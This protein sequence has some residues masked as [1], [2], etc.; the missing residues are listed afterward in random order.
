MTEAEA[1]QLEQLEKQF[2]SGVPSDDLLTRCGEQISQLTELQ[3]SRKASELSSV[4]T[5]RLETLET[6]FIKGVPSEEDVLRHE[7]LLNQADS[8]R[9]EKLRLTAAI[10]TESPAAP[11]SQKKFHSL[12]FPA[13]IFGLLAAAAGIFLLA[14][15]VFESHM[16]VGGICAA[17]GVVALVAA[18]IMQN[19]HNLMAKMQAQASTGGMTAAQRSLIQENEQAASTMESV[20]SAFLAD[21]PAD[22]NGS[23]RRR[24]AELSTNRS[25]YLPLL[26]R[27]RKLAQQAAEQD[28]RMAELTE[29]LHE[30]L[31]PYFHTILDF[32]TA[33]QTLELR[34][35]QFQ[36][37]SH[38]Q[39]EIAGRNAVLTD[40]IAKLEAT[41]ST[42][43]LPYCGEVSH[44]TFRSALDT[45]RRDADSYTTA[46]AHLTQ[47]A[48]A[49]ADRDAQCAALLS[50]QNEFCTAYGLT[51][52]IHDRQALKAAERDA[53]A[54]ARLT[55]EAAL[56]DKA[57]QC[58]IEEHGHKPASELNASDYDLDGLKSAEQQLITK[59]NELHGDILR[60]EQR[61]RQLR[62]DIDRIPDLT[63]E[64]TR[65]TEQKAADTESRRLLDSTVEYL[66]KARES[67][68][69][70]Y[71]GGVQGHFARYLNRLTGEETAHIAVNTDLEVQLE[72]AGSARALPHFSAGQADAVHL[73][74]RLALSDALFEEGTAF[75]ILDDPFVN[76]DDHH[77]AQAL[78]LL[79]EL[80][81]DRQIVY[82]V[83]NS[84][85]SL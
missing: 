57:M 25:L 72:R 67:L 42:F 17:L 83:C 61:R 1:R 28:K 40:E 51:I 41:F 27:S 21:Y 49:L 2:A 31:S 79:R 52:A 3:H 10:P 23:L 54:I 15:P 63:D 85:R 50:Q 29:A 45:L 32:H 64:L 80:A 5:A 36:Q 81:H 73:C 43:L 77:T 7:H 12:F 37:I 14:S 76:L 70:S 6:F 44:N 39:Q 16:V 13:L 74:M 71:L 68:S 65:L 53:E 38:K 24:L 33:L 75:M 66:Q 48:A 35:Q 34:K 11:A 26:E 60:L 20:V 22:P 47:R 18:V 84:S 78:E 55:R 82:L 4:D 69:A 8:I 56:A 46:A 30:A 58:F 19:N 62:A 59:Q 9:R